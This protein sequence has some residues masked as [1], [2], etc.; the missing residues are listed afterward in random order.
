M[1]DKFI[2]WIA[3]RVYDKQIHREVA[4]ELAVRQ[5]QA[6]EKAAFNTIVS[7]SR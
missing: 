6:G 3:K 2:T 5:K 4:E 1:L 7:G